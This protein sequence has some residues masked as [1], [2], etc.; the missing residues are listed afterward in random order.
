MFIFMSVQKSR[1]EFDLDDAC[2]LVDFSEECI[3]CRYEN[4]LSL[5]CF[6][7][8]YALCRVLY[9]ISENTDLFA[10]LCRVDGT[11]AGCCLLYISE[12][13]ANPTFINGR[14]GS[15]LNVYTRPQ[16][17]RRGIAGK[18]M[19]MLLSEA[20]RLGLDFVEL[21][22][23]DVGYPLYKSVGFEDAVSKYHNM[24]FVIDKRNM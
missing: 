3:Y 15:V 21:K 10:F 11:A 2:L 6:D 12:K 7:V 13:P 8:E 23:T 9:N 1:Y 20:G 4:T 24:K 19:G 16:F 22:S 14:T 17:R 5:C 18:L